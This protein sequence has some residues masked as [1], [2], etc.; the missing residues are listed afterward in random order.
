MPRNA[1][2]LL[3][4]GGGVAGAATAA[5]A[6]RRG[7]R[8]TL[9]EQ[10]R[11]G[12]QYGSSHGPSRIIRL[13]Y[14]GAHYVTLVR[15][16]YDLWH[17]LEHRSRRQ[18]LLPTGGLDFGLPETPSLRATART[19]EQC[20]VEFEQLSATDL[21][22]RFPQLRVEPEMEGMYQP[23]AGVL[24]ADACV[25]ALAQDARA[26]GATI[27]EQ[28][29][30][31]RLKPVPGGVTAQVDGAS[32]YAGAAVIAAGSWT[33]RLLAELGRQVPLTVTREQV[34]YFAASST[35]YSPD[36]FPVTIEHRAG[37]PPLI[38]MFPQL[39]PGGGVKLMLDRNGPEIAADDLSGTVDAP[40]LASLVSHATKRLRTLGQVVHAETCRYTMTPDED[41]I[42][43][44]LPDH[45]QIGIAS[46]CSGHGFKFGP[47]VGETMV[48]LI[49]TGKTARP[50][51]GF[52]LDR[53]ALAP[54]QA[55]SRS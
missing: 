34:A 26:H 30:V 9:I 40:A 49:T 35:E 16:A 4:V 20:A 27:R 5:A 55:W 14:S 52:A 28:A 18:L 1:P 13:A 47:V 32:L 23:R 43:D 25:Q 21:A 8:T 22:S 51:A 45:P 41:F 6:A 3:V 15:E 19:M 10:F 46:A 36:R 7:L 2:D 29:Q 12:H 42:L 38:S 11:L 44:L 24:N 37:D 48:D 31:S 17:E 33:G 53:P 39:S 54:G 50:V